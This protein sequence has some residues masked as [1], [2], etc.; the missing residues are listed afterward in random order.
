VENPAISIFAEVIKRP[1]FTPSR[2]PPSPKPE[3]AASAPKPETLDLVGVI[4]S[5]DR[6]MALL[7]P[8]NKTDV[9]FAVEGQSIAG[10][11]VR[12]IKPT[13]VVLGWGNDS[14]VIKIS[15]SG[16]SSTIGNP[17]LSGTATLPAQRSMAD[18]Q[19]PI[20]EWPW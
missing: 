17:S 2:R 5:A 19:H 1:L 7:R 8:R 12:D 10:W 15:D 20:E 11:E 18:A 13:Q 3:V 6:R 4:I 16:K 14:E 9:L